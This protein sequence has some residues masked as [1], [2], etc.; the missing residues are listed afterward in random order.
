MITSQYANTSLP[1]LI[2]L[3]LFH[4]PVLF[5]LF[6]HRH[7][8]VFKSGCSLELTYLLILG[9]WFVASWKLAVSLDTTIPCIVNSSISS[10]SYFIVIVVYMQRALKVLFRFE[11]QA[12]LDNFRRLPKE[13]QTEQVSVV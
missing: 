3:V 10:I 9:F 1:I 6:L 13:Q 7:S 11:L 12:A 8:Q 5:F 2:L 4:V